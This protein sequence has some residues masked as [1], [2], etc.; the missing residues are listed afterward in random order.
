M[1]RVGKKP[2]PVPDK[3]KITY[4]DRVITVK[5]EKGSLERTIHPSIDLTI[6]D[7]TINVTMATIIMRC[8]PSR[9]SI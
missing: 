8:I 5:G 9:T 7:N 4:K 2:I 6:A 1:S 3:T